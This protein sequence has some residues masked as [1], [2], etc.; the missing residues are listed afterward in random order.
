[1]T[2]S[3][4]QILTEAM[5][6]DQTERAEL[7]MRL[8]DTLDSDTDSGWEEA[9]A[10]EIKLRLDRLDRGEVKC[11]PWEEARQIIRQGGEGGQTP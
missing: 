11:I 6:L 8:I 3:A 4:E 5:E 7:A 2:R 1:M 9:W 10:K